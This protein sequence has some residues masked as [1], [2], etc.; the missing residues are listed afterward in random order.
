MITELLSGRVCVRSFFL[1]NGDVKFDMKLGVSVI[2]AFCVC[3]S[4]RAHMTNDA[5]Q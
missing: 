1:L 3:V 5:P 4:A 2:T